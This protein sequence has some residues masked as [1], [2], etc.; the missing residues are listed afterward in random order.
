MGLTLG[1]IG[2][3]A[4][5]NLRLSAAE[6]TGNIKIVSAPKVSTLDNTAATIQQGVSIPV[7]VVSAQGVNTQFFNALLK[8]EV[9]PHVTQDGNISLKIDISKNE[10]DF[11][12]TGASGN[13]SI[14]KKEAHTELLVKDGD[15]TVIGGIYTRNTSDGYKKVP[16]FADLPILGPMFRNHKV[17]DQRSELLI[18]ITPRIINRAAAEVRTD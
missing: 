5:L 7:S 16:F 1:S 8:L 12:Q 18:F 13:P 9:L 4:N 2:G 6:E 17:T 15:T 10:P 14:R 11:G 3:A